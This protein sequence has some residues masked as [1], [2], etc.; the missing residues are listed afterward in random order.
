MCML[1]TCFS[2]QR[3]VEV[4]V[5]ALKIHLSAYKTIRYYDPGDINYEVI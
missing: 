2:K 4:V 3:V 1:L 5:I